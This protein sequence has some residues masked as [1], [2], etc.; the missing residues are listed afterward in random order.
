[1][2]IQ[3]WAWVLQ[4]G[5]RAAVTS[6][7]RRSKVSIYWRLG[8]YTGPYEPEPQF[9]LINM[10]LIR[11]EISWRSSNEG[12]PSMGYLGTLKLLQH[13]VCGRAT[14]ERLACLEYQTGARQKFLS[15]LTYIFVVGLH[16][17]VGSVRP[18]SDNKA[19]QYS[20]SYLW[21]KTELPSSQVLSDNNQIA[22]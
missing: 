4:S 8:I 7:K 5:R 22:R 20:L 10:R 2:H 19:V 6:D 21:P 14:E 11:I 3:E 9:P 18:R 13:Q 16:D 17:T 12:S 1:M 15:M